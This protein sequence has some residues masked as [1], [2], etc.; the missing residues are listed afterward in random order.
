MGLDSKATY[1]SYWKPWVDSKTCFV[2]NC[3]TYLLKIYYSPI[4]LLSLYLICSDI[5]DADSEKIVNR[6]NSCKYLWLHTGKQQCITVGCIPPA[7]WLYPVVSHWRGVSAQP[8]WRQTPQIQ[9][10]TPLNANP[11]GGRPPGHVTCDVCREATPQSPWTEW[12]T[13]LKTLPF[14]KLRLRAVNIS[15]WSNCSVWVLFVM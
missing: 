4:Y 12:H 5:F 9:I 13:G 10:Q 6:V 7:C 2:I 11:L 14:P 3:R 15:L 1:V 8:P